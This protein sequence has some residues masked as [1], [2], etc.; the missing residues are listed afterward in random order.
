MLWMWWLSD[1][2]MCNTRIACSY[3]LNRKHAL[4]QV[5][6]IDTN[7]DREREIEIL[8]SSISAHSTEE[9]KAQPTSVNP[10]RFSKWIGRSHF[11]SS[12]RTIAM[13]C[14]TQMC[15]HLQIVIRSCCLVLPKDWLATQPMARYK[16]C[17]VSRTEEKEHWNKV[18]VCACIARKHVYELYYR[19]R[20]HQVKCFRSLLFI[21]H[22]VTDH[23]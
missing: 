21:W 15:K 7:W 10:V 3:E 12:N 13:E 1:G 20:A 11:T 6:H 16:K 9:K 2:K 18:C 19:K 4:G 22:H 23:L 14:L 5:V 17:V 8:S